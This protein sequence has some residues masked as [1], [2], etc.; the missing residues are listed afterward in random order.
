MMKRS[1]FL[2]LISSYI[3]LSCK[4]DEY[5]LFNDVGR[6]QFGPQIGD[7]YETN[8]QLSD[9]SKSHTFFYE[10]NELVKDTVYFNIYTVGGVTN[11]DRPYKLVQEQVQNVSNAVPNVHYQAFDHPNSAGLYV[12][13]ANSVHAMVPVVLLRD[14]SLSNETVTL[15]FN[16][17]ANDH[18]QLGERT[19]LWR[20]LT[21]TDRLTK[22]D[23]WDNSMT[24]YYLG[25]YSIV[26]HQF[27][28]DVTGEKWDQDMLAQVR[29]QSDLINYYK[30]LFFMA[31]I[32]YN[33]EH[34]SDHLRDED[35]E[36]VVFP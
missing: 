4:Q 18:F 5:K 33:N 1:F 20:K 26:K 36:L 31:L 32:D 25:K 29:V 21:F 15:K 24:Q 35:G 19:K 17:V 12:I 2:L 30:T 22:P 16:L 27:M 10:S 23:A 34:P 11:F 7:L 9:T 28:I 14:P 13:K 3:L 6:I 8:R